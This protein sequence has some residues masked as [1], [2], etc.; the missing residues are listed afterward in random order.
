MT[1]NVAKVQEAFLEDRGRMI[2]DI[3]NIVRLLYRMCQWILLDEL[4]IQCIG[5]KFV[6][7]LLSSD[8]REYRIAVSAELKEQ[9]ENDP[10]FIS[11]II[12]CDE[13]W[14]FGHDPEMKQQSS[15]W[16]TPASPWP[17]KAQQVRSNVQS[18]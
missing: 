17:K 9:A 18:M 2:H 7:R 1:E 6:L 4:N 8:Q 15:Q 13:S 3:C 11:N 10:N 14:V 5:A 12:T 16:K